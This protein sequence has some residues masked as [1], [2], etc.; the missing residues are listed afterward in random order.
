MLLALCVGAAATAA[1]QQ[2]PKRADVAATRADSL[3]AL[4]RLD[5][6]VA[7]RDAGADLWH[8]RGVL[9]W[10]LSQGKR[11]IG[12]RVDRAQLR[13]TRTADSSLAEATAL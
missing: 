1:S 8:A 5:S 6:L 4:A 11:A 13:L 3:V 10:Q 7:R 12:T 2:A 9:A